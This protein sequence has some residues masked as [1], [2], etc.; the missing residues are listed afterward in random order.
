MGRGL[1]NRSCGENASE[2]TCLE[3]SKRLYSRDSDKATYVQDPSLAPPT[4][5]KDRIQRHMN[6][7]R[8][9]GG[10]DRDR[11]ELGEKTADEGEAG[12]T[13]GVHLSTH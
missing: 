3:I 10:Y 9:M 6:G 5:C 7:V 13:M 12:G 11:M 8:W 1:H 4:G 2:R